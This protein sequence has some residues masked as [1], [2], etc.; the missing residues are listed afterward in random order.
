MKLTSTQSARLARSDLGL[1]I[2]KAITASGLSAIEVIEVLVLLL[3]R[4]TAAEL[5]I[6]EKDKG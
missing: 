1:E 6:A 5:A 3:H 4:W 2:S